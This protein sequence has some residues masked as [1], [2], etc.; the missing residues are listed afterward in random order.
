VTTG[1]ISAKGRAIGISNVSFE[2]FLQTDA[3]I[4]FG[5]SGGPL[6]NLQGEVIGIATAI[7]AGAENIGFAVPVN[8]LKEVLPQLRD[9]GKVSRGF[10]GIGIAN[11]SYEQA[12]AW[13]LPGT[14]GALVQSVEEGKPAGKAGVQHGD[15]VLSVDGRK[16]KTT[17]DLIDYVSSRGPSS[18]VTL[19]IWRDGKTLDLK[20]RLEER[21]S[22]DEQVADADEPD[23]AE[24]GMEWLGMSYQSLSDNLR[25]SLG[26][27]DTLTGGVIVTSVAPTSPLYE[28]RVRRNTVITEVNGRPVKTVD[29][30]EKEVK[31]A[32][33]KSYVRL[34]ARQ[35]GAQGQISPP[36]F[37]VVQVP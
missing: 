11:L 32:K 6:I 30:F 18:T 22:D 21:P 19:G 14:D 20:V 16:V 7:N 4:N 12:Q 34:Y 37:A 24:K 26:V 8:T 33:S 27:P 5:N 2:N 17:R 28:Q 1:V 13:G 31:S 10:L 3:A 23:D 25:Q 9:K 35:L 29:Q 15:V 36:F